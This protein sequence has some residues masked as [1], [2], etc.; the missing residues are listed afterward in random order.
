MRTPETC[1]EFNTFLF[2]VKCVR[3]LDLLHSEMLDLGN[4]NHNALSLTSPCFGVAE[5]SLS[6]RKERDVAERQGEVTF[7]PFA[8]FEL[9]SM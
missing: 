1:D 2:A 7:S 9:F 4:L 5:T 6:L 8:F 3:L